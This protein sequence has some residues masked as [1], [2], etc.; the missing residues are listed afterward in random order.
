MF[1]V[2]KIL[3]Y[4]FQLNLLYFTYSLQKDKTAMFL[5]YNWF[6]CHIGA[7]LWEIQRQVDRLS[8]PSSPAAVGQLLQLRRQVLFLQFD[9]AVR[10]LIR[11]VLG[12]IYWLLTKQRQVF[13]ESW[14]E[15]HCVGI[16][17]TPWPTHIDNL[18][19][20]TGKHNCLEKVSFYH[21]VI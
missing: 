1:F 18:W 4:F 21:Q 16:I 9:T 2:T 8:D 11:W 13:K 5:M 6:P 14:A 10:H 3:W 15:R 20:L 7:E 12:L 19:N 17:S